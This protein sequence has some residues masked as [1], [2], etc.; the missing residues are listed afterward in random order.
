MVGRI[1][2]VVAVVR[3][4]LE[5]AAAFPSI[6]LGQW[7]DPN[8]MR[9]RRL[10]SDAMEL[11]HRQEYLNLRVMGYERVSV[12]ERIKPHPRVNIARLPLPLDISYRFMIR[13]VDTRRNSFHNLNVAG[14]EIILGM[15]DCSGPKRH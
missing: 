8:G 14:I 11:W 3:V 1:I 15:R 5:P 10:G 2:T 12:R 4:G 9:E 13:D 7:G 6:R